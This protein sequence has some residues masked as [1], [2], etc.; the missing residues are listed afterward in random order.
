MALW[1]PMRLSMVL[2]LYFNGVRLYLLVMR[3][4]GVGRS[5]RCDQM[6][7]DSAPAVLTSHGKVKVGH[8][9]I[10]TQQLRARASLLGFLYLLQRFGRWGSITVK[11]GAWLALQECAE[12]RTCVVI[13]ITI[14]WGP[15]EWNWSTRF[16]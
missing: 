1:L 5:S 7:A 9:H 6:D 8:S 12:R 16:A 2:S 15:E 14:L 11:K 13:G 4:P 10:T 3:I